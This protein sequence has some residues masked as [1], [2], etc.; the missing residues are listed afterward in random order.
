MLVLMKALIKVCTKEDRCV[1]AYQWM[2]SKRGAPDLCISIIMENKSVPSVCLVLCY[3][4]ESATLR[5]EEDRSSDQTL[6]NSQLL[7]GFSNKK[8]EPQLE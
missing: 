2:H 3:R 1:C 7:L 4:S 6:T 5:P 8:V